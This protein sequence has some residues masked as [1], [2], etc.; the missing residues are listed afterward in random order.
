MGK[1]SRDQALEAGAKIQTNIN[2]DELDSDL[3]QEVL[4]DPIALGREAT[5]L[6][7]NRGRVMVVTTDG[8]ILPPGGKVHIVSVPVD[9]SRDWKDVVKA[10]GPNTG[11]GW[12]VWK[13]GEQYPPVVGA[14]LNFQQ[15]ILVNFGKDTRSEDNLAWAKAQKLKPISPRAALA[16]GEHC[17][18]LN[19]NLGLEYM[20]VVSLVPC[21][22]GG[23]RRFVYSWWSRSERKA[24]RHRF[25]SGWD[26]DCWFGFARESE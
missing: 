18:T 1:V 12:D 10:A 2:W 13:M 22:F 8:I 5:R 7:Q 21:S 26:G 14:T 23:E 3:L 17:P 19:K 9:E 11:K 24:A 6:L 16:I 4:R 15:I 20:A 25:G